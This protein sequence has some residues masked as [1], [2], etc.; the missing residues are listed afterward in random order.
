MQDPMT[1]TRRE[2][3]ILFGTGLMGALVGCNTKDNG[4]GTSDEDSIESD[5]E[6]SAAAESD[7]GG[8]SA[9]GGESSGG[10][11]SGNVD[12]TGG[13][14]DTAGDTSGDSGGGGGT[15][16]AGGADAIEDCTVTDS[17]IEGPFYISDAPIRSNLD[18][19]GDA[20]IVLTLSGRVLDAECNPIA[21]AVVEIWHA[22]PTTTPVGE[23]T[24]ADSV[25]YDNTSSEMRY[26]GQTPTDSEGRYTFRTKKPGW[27]LNGSRFRPMHIHVK[28]WAG[29]EERLTTQ[30][31]FA[32][33]PHIEGD[34]W[35][36]E[37]RAVVLAS[38]GVGR[39]SGTFNF[40]LA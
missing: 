10:S 21:D 37:D 25:T 22:D 24:A 27:Y 8:G 35:A 29:G 15:D 28:V 39:E 9:G 34:A 12:T 14:G 36:S 33:D 2:S 5:D 11:E 40:T 4:A 26:R 16:T 17:D 32:G 38:D 31:Y 1:F 6:Y 7:G 18:L 13:T 30:L 20:G 23:L 19:Y 3:L